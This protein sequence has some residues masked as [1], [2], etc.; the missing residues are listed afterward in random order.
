MK[1]F[2]I[3]EKNNLKISP[4]MEKEVEVEILYVVKVRKRSIDFLRI[5]KV[6][7]NSIKVDPVHNNVEV[8]KM[9]S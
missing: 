6:L 3:H 4:V 9:V 5:N 1:V 2:K 8:V 7:E